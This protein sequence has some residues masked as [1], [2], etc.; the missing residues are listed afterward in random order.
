MWKKIHNNYIMK[1]W[2][3][4]KCKQEEDYEMIGKKEN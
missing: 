3:M 2:W 1:P 4:I